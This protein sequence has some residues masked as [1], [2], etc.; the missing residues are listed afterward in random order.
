MHTLPPVLRDPA[1]MLAQAL[2]ERRIAAAGLDVIPVEPPVEPLPSLLQAYRNKEEWLTGRL[3][4]TP[5]IAFH[6]PQAWDDIRLK[7]AETM[8]DVLVEGLNT[9]VIPPDSD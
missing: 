1:P 9:N 3:I 2:R 4:I 7:S 5:H 6:T 8:R